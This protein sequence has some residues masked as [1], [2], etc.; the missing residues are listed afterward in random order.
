MTDT[1]LILA[2]DDDDDILTVLEARLQSADYD[3]LTADCA[4]T[5]LEMIAEEP[6]DLIV[7]DV[8]M[9]G[10]G[11]KGLLHEVS[12]GWPHIPVIL[13]T[14]YGNVP[15]AVD[16]LKNGAADYLT[17]PFDGLELVSRINA[18]LE[19]R[20]PK[21]P[22]PSR[23]PLEDFWG[24]Q[25]PAM[26]EFV[27]R[28]ERVAA[29]DVSVMLLGESGTGKER[30]ARLIHDGSK[31]SGG[32]FVPVDCGST[33][34]TLLES[35]LFG[36]VRGAFTNAVRDKRGLIEEADGGTLFLDEIGN[37]SPEMQT[38]LL[39]F[40]QERTIR[41]V[42]DTTER[43][44]DCRV[45]AATNADLLRMVHEGDFR[46]DLYFRLR[47]VTLEIPPL[48]ERTED[49]PEL[50]ERF[51]AMYCDRMGRPAVRIGSRT[52]EK[53]RVHPWPGNI[54]ELMHAI[55]G[56]LVFCDGETLLPEHVQLTPPAADSR[57]SGPEPLSLEENERRTILRALNQCGWVKKKAAEKLGIS[58]RAIHYKINKYELAPERES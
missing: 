44:V 40:L 30:V 8:K 42:G 49:I 51:T 41:R 48:R 16:T 14:A 1:P 17:K 5:A 52:L 22:K 24:T 21:V 7:S 35:E 56:G 39:R 19:Q 23:L 55:E 58:R 25:S 12:R 43:K 26:Q 15:E 45:V 3:V 34:S 28:L 53:L 36:H 33:Q 6:V 31:R 54:R 46:E 47:V 27:S 2:V 11:G 37:I 29:A 50:A 10:M 4:E 57:D 20:P 13:L 38:R 32:P 9:P 18:A